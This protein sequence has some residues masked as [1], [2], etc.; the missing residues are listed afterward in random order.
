MGCLSSGHVLDSR[1]IGGAHK[2]RVQHITCQWRS[3]SGR[4]RPKPLVRSA[5]TGLANVL[6]V[7]CTAGPACRSQSGAAVAA[8]ELPCSEWRTATAVT[9]SRWR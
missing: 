4:R 1:W 6:G 7:S 8:N 2:H 9:P 3:G 5:S